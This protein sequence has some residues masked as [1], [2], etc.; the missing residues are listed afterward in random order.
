[1]YL[2]PHHTTT[3]AEQTEVP[4]DFRHHLLKGYTATYTRS[5][6]LRILTQYYVHTDVVIYMHQFQATQDS[7]LYCTPVTDYFVLLLYREGQAQITGEWLDHWLEAPQI[8][9]C[10]VLAGKELRIDVAAGMHEMICCCFTANFA[11][12]M[13]GLYPA[14]WQEDVLPFQFTPPYWLRYQWDALLQ[15]EQDA[16]WYTV[17]VAERIRSFW[18]FLL[19]EHQ[20]IEHIKQAGAQHPELPELVVV[21]A[22][23]VKQ[24]ID[25]RMDEDLKQR[26]M[27]RYVQWN[28]GDM[29]RGFI[30]VFNISIRQYQIQQRMETALRLVQQT[31]EPVWL[32]GRMCGYQLPQH[33]IERFK[34]V[35]G[36]TPGDM[37]KEQL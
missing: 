29:Q 8:L 1:M 17:L 9:Y 10:R 30:A 20:T 31:Q 37:R 36:Q 18:L 5:S 4:I 6:E 32:I 34:K 14:L 2:R 15:T 13:I 24:L 25:T 16:S 26:E 22:Y 12:A 21:K 33:F 28:I 23:R 19:S 7:T 3:T 35:F 27:S 11:Q